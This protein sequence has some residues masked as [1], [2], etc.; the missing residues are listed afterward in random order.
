MTIGDLRAL[1]GAVAGRPEPE[2]RRAV[3]AAVERARAADAYRKRLGR[4]H[5]A[6]GNGTLV[7]ACEAAAPLPASEPAFLRALATV[8]DV[9]AEDRGA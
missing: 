3:R 4:I 7:Q 8:C 2:R 1:A 5:P 9:L 6:W